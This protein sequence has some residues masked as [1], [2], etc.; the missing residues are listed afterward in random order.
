MKTHEAPRA[1]SQVIAVEDPQH[2]EFEEEDGEYRRRHHQR[3]L[4]Y[5]G[6][7]SPLSAELD[8]VPWPRRFNATIL[9][10]FD[11][12]SD[13]EEF[14]LKYEATIESTGG[15]RAV[16]AKALVLA[17]KGPVQLVH[18]PPQWPQ[19]FLESAKD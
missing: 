19:T 6:P 9:P 4:C 2:E 10:Q 12:E 14:L 13:P 16:K 11:G 7:M 8:E 17:L 1:R 18:R 5:D 3:G 15:G